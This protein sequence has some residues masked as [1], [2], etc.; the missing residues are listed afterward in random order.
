MRWASSMGFAL[1]KG[2]LD[3]GRGVVASETVGLSEEV[4]TQAVNYLKERKQFGNEIGE[5]QALQHCAALART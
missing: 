5:F 3:I 1:L 2:V 4:F